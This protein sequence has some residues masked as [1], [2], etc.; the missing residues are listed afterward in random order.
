MRLTWSARTVRSTI[1]MSTGSHRAESF[2]HPGARARIIGL[3]YGEQRVGLA[4]ADPTRM[5]AQSHGT[6]SPKE[7]LAELARIHEAERIA[8]LVIGWP[9]ELD[10]SEGPAVGRV[11]G[12]LKRLRGVLPEAELVRWDERFSSKRAARILV[13]AG[14]RKSQR[15]KKGRLDQAAAAVILQE[16]LDENHPSSSLDD[17]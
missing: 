5:F 9:L 13:E 10:G 4:I 15:R 6:F 2:L 17:V 11:K 8:I 7:A 1:N 3:D 16:Y 12:Y 14:V